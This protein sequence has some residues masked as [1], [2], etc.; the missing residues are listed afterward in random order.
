MTALLL[1]G[2]LA[3]LL[4]GG[5]ALVR[6]S[7][8]IAERYRL[9]PLLVGMVIAGFGTSMPELV[10]SVRATVGGTPAIA[11]GNVIG[12]NISN[13][14]LILAVA[15]LIRPIGRPPRLFM[16]DGLILMAVTVAVVL[17]GLQGRIPGWQGGIMVVL[18]A[19]FIVFQYLRDRRANTE[20]LAVS[21]QPP[22]PLPA[23]LP[24]RLSISILLI[25]AGLGG[26]IAGGDW[27]V[28]GAVRLARGL[29]V[30]EGL[31]GLTI[32]AV[33]TS[34]PELATSALAS[35]RGQSELAYGNVL[36]SNMFNLLGILGCAA[37][38]GPLEVPRLMV[39]ADGPVM[40]GATALMLFFL[41]S[42]TRLV[43]W[44]GG[45]MLACYALYI[46]LRAALS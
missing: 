45:A 20:L 43:R 6:G 5:E 13:I 28:D 41:A 38:A 8:A 46:A 16:P 24:R 44:E 14:L 29:G 7:V 34:L 36:G 21:G 15:A 25:L 39:Y 26:L 2:G 37:I 40:I 19:G 1:V 30:S 9:S 42:G 12:S 11:A 35:I 18:L 22:V 27:F 23:E 10:V 17:L 3:L 4:I 32:V 31:I 33:G